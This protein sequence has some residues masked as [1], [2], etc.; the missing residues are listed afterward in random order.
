MPSYVQDQGP[1]L[2]RRGLYTFW[3]RTVAPPSM[4]AF[5]AAGRETCTVRESRTNTPLQAL[6]VLNDVTFVEAARALAE[7]VIHEGGKTLEERLS[8]GLSH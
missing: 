5:D 3:K 8:L 1:S 4:V 2:Y 6:D 7:R